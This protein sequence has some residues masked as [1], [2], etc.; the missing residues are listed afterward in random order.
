[1]YAT[2]NE[3]GKA[4]GFDGIFLFIIGFYIP[5]TCASTSKR[6]AGSRVECLSPFSDF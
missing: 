4:V 2:K 6:S 1:M 3:T 5:A